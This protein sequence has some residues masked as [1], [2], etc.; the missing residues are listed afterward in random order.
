[1]K[2]DF[3]TGKDPSGESIS[4]SDVMAAMDKILRDESVRYEV[5]I[6]I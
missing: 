4:R 6:F 2:K 1:M 3:A 5:F